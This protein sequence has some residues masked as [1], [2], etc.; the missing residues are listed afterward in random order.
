M[1]VFVKS[2]G[3][4]SLTKRDFVASGGEGEIYSKARTAFKIYTGNTPCIPFAKMQELAAITDSNVIAPKELILNSKNKPIGYTMRHVPNT[5]ALCQI[6]TKAFKTRNKVTPETMLDLVKKM[7]TTIEH[8]HSKGALIVDLNEMNFLVNKKLTNV[9]FIDVDSYQTKS[10]PAT[11]IM[12]SIRDR[13]AKSFN[14]MTDWF[15]FGIVS[16]Q[17]FIGIHPYKGKHPTLKTL[18]ERMLANIPVFHKD[19]GYPR[20]CM[21]FDYIPEAYRDWYKAIFHKG[22]RIA[23]PSIAH[24]VIVVPVVTT[25]IRSNSDFDIQELKSYDGNITNFLSINGTRVVTTD[26]G[27]FY[28]NGNLEMNTRVGSIAIT[29]QKN[30]V[31]NCGIVFDSN[32][33]NG[34]LAM[35]DVLENETIDCNLNADDIMSYDGRVYIKQTDKISEIEFIELP[36]KVLVAATVVSTTLENATKFFNGVSIQNV[37]GACVASVM[38][39]SKTCHQIIIPEMKG[40]QVI[41]AKY[42]KNV[43]VI[44]GIK[45]GKYDKFVFKLSPDFKTYD[46]RKVDDISYIGIN[47]TVL[48]NGVVVYLNEDEE[49]EIFANKMGKNDVKVIDSSSISGDMRLY[50]DGTKVLFSESNKIYR[51]QMKSD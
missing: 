50:A 34:T 19:V 32:G 46:L 9:Y 47:F 39:Q 16:F 22:E 2:K 8:I 20:V 14:K 5:Y 41:D 15:S 33:E 35:L 49:I 7:Q 10:F 4:V 29:S 12:P 13:H 11:A 42:D 18:D 44:I 43:L 30:K 36:H 48:E 27:S 23:P 51:I 1:K 25:L 6:F 37:L 38:P 3:E 31:M 28:I 17:M 45:K 26:K 21:P 24:A 40:Y